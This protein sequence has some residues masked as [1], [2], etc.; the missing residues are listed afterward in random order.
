MATPV[1][2]EKQ[3]RRWF[4]GGSDIAAIAGLS[5]YKTALDVYAEKL[6]LVPPFAGNQFTRWGKRLEA[7][8]ADCYAETT[9][10]ELE[11]GGFVM[12]EKYPWAGGNLD[13]QNRAAR[14]IVEVKTANIRQADRWGEEGT[15]EIPEEYIA[16]CAWYLML[17]GY[18]V[19]DVPVLLGGNDFRIYRVERDE[20]LEQFLIDAGAR[21]WTDHIEKQVQPEV[22][23][24]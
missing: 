6:G 14:K 19:A 9:G 4:I 17:T 18:S 15:D 22:A 2:E 11:P 20:E 21:F 1:V 24:G 5:P 13:R 3:G 23:A 12:H 8:I 16:Q 7:V 10:L